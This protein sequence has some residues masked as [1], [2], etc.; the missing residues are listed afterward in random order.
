MVERVF[1]RDGLAPFSNNHNHFYLMM[2]ILAL[3]WKRKV[4]IH[5][6]T[7]GILL[8]EK[9]RL[10]VGVMPHFNSMGLVVSAN[11]INAVY[12]NKLRTSCN[13]QGC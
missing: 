13:G 1:D 3:L 5:K 9:G 2:N 10:F 7:I 11:A 8:K 6:K 12:G 4:C